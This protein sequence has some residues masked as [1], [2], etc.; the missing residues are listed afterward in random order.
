MLKILQRVLL[1]DRCSLKNLKLEDLC[2]QQIFYFDISGSFPGCNTTGFAF[3]YHTASSQVGENVTLGL[4]YSSCSILLWL[5]IGYG[6]CFSCV[7]VVISR[8]STLTQSTCATKR[9]L[10]GCAVLRRFRIRMLA[11][12]L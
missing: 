11:E 9:E 7:P 12:E 4:S 10:L 6:D 2:L 1:I 3:T 5:H 8:M